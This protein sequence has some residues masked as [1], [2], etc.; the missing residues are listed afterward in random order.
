[1]LVLEIL[2]ASTMEMPDLEMVVNEEYDGSI[3]LMKRKENWTLHEL[4]QRKVVGVLFCQNYSMLW[5]WK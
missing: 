5:Y 2:T 3:G 4:C 1:M